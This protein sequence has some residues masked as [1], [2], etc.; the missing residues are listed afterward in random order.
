MRMILHLKQKTRK[1]RKKENEKSIDTFPVG[2]ARLRH[3]RVPYS[4]HSDME[5]M[6]R[7]HARRGRPSE[8]YQQIRL[9]GVYG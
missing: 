7:I 2:G 8:P 6:D 3:S 4:L 9:T 1:R 5:R